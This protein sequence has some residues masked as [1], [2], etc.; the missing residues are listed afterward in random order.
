MDSFEQVEEHARRRGKDVEVRRIE[1]RLQEIEK[2]LDVM[3]ITPTRRHKEV[4]TASCLKTRRPLQKLS[5]MGKF[6]LTIVSV[7]AVVCLAQWVGLTLFIMGAILAAWAG[8]AMV[9]MGVV[10]IAYKIFLKGKD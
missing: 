8:K 6:V 1:A 5:N 4:L 10:W 3:A 9:I 7:A 2:E